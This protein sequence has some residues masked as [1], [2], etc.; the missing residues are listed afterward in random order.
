MVCEPAYY[1]EF[2]QFN[3]QSI[4]EPSDLLAVA[5]QM[6]ALRTLLLNGLFTSNMTVWWEPEI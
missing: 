5:Q 1:Q 2:K 6:V 3:I 4:Q